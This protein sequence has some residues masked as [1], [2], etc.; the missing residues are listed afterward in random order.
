MENQKLSYI[1]ALIAVF[2]WSTVASAFKLS[3]EY[4]S[5][6]QLVLYAV[7]T[8][9]VILF[10]ILLYQKKLNKI[11]EHFKRRFFIYTIFRYFKSFF[12]V[13]SFISSL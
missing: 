12:D 11:L 2:L 4:L 10:M 7:I 13:Y 9:I 1:Y 8:S 3:L 5:P 6:I